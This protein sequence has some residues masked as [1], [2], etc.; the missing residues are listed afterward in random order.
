MAISWFS[1]VLG[2]EGGISGSHEDIAG[3]GEGDEIVL[4]IG[5]QQSS[6]DATVALT[7]ASLTEMLPITQALYRASASEP[8][9]PLMLAIVTDVSSSR[10]NCAEQVNILSTAI[11]R[12]EYTL[13]TV[14]KSHR[15]K[16]VCQNLVEEVKEKR[17]YRNGTELGKGVCP[18][19]FRYEDCPGGA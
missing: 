7:S 13:A 4:P 10:K 6:G 3:V 2:E 14:Q 8:F 1:L 19:H 17:S 12:N 9:F 15:L 18:I 16:T 11:H 5:N